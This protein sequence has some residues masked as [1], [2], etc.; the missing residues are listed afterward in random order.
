MTVGVI[1]KIGDFFKKIGSG[2]VNVAKKVWNN[3][4]KPIGG[5]LIP[6]IESSGHPAGLAAGQIWRAAA[7]IADR[8]LGSR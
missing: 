1:A 7:P 5:A 2:V 6:A 8:L 4:A 3:V